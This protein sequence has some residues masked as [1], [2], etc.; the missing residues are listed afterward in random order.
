MVEVNGITLIDRM[1]NQL[2]GLPLN[3]VVIVVGYEG[4]K[5]VDYIGIDMMI[6]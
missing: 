3:R 6:R 1:L 2:S 5:L 4:K